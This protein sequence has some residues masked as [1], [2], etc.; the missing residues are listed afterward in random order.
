MAETNTENA[1]AT[2]ADRIAVQDVICAVSLHSDLDEPELA[3]ALFTD[4]AIMDFS[5][6]FGA[7]SEISARE[8]RQKSLEFLP[9]F[10]GRQHQITNFQ[11]TIL[12][13]H[14]EARSQVRAT[15]ALGEATW[16]ACATY[17]HTLVRTASGWR[18][19]RQR[20]AL[21]FQEGQHLI[22]QARQIVA[23]RKSAASG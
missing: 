6:V 23:D 17:F 12:G 13:D 19:S 16:I 15:H 7:G 8:H 20:T 11:I 14:A 21:I 4:D 1:L 3:L 5:S 2:L 9:G 10:D 18:I 22:A